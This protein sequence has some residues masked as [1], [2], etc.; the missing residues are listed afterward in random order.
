MTDLIRQIKVLVVDDSAFMR[1]VISDLLEEDPRIKV[2]DRARNGKEAVEKVVKLQ[3]DVVTLDV[4]MPEM[5]GLAALK[6]IMRL[7]PTP[8]IMVSSITRKGAEITVK[9]LTLGAVDFVTKPSGTISLDM[10][11]VAQEL[12]EKIIAAAS[13]AVDK[14]AGIVSLPIAEVRKLPLVRKGQVELVAIAASTGGPRAIQSILEKIETTSMVPIVIVQ[15]MPKGFTKS[16]AER[17]N[18]VS[19]LDVV[20]G[21]DNL[22]LKPNLA[23]V[24]PGGSHLIV[25]YNKMGQLVCRLSDMPPLHSVKPAADLLF[26]SVADTVGGASLG[27]ILT[28]MG[29][30]GAEGAKAIRQKGGYVIAESS[31]TCVIYGMPKAA[32]ESGSVDEVLP[33]YEI[34]KRLEELA[35]IK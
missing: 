5:D 33:L 32:V 12:R 10:Q 11:V 26:L 24:A 22:P 31:E 20:E 2:I 13:V 14:L 23:V 15:H 16:F 18:E 1:K 7:K 29:R 8:V 4:E 34:P 30:D 3:P 25:E 28:G 19:K 9:A 35:V 6:E 21:Y 17:L 27:V